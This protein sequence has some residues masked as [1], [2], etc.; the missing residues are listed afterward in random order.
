MAE[1]KVYPGINIQWPYSEMILSGKKTIETRT[2][3]IPRKYLGEEMVLIETPG[4]QGKFKAQMK[5]VIVFKECFEYLSEDE[6]Y[7][8]SGKHYVTP[9][10]DWAWTSTKTKWGWTV[11]VLRIFPKA[12]ELSG[13]RGIKYCQ[14]ICV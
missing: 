5:G 8:D 10:S 2:Y 12:T 6:F 4:K 9:E 14:R 3:P 7:A 13:R 11:K 1:R